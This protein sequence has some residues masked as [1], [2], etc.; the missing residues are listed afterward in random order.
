MTSP[1]IPSSRIAAVFA[2]LV[3]ASGTVATG[4]STAPAHAA[5]APAAKPTVASPATS[6]SIWQAIDA[7]SAELAKAIEGGKLAGVHHLAFAIRDLVA[8]LPAHSSDLPADKL[9]KVKSGVKFVATLA[10]RLDASGDGNDKA[11]SQENYDKLIGVLKS[12]RA[13]YLK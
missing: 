10:D 7:K 5:P 9:A 13:N 3:L 12:L 8:T 6:A 4:L 2:A 11:G 1:I